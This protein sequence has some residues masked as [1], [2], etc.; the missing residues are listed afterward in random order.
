MKPTR[1]FVDGYNLTL[2]QGTGVATYARNL[3]RAL[4]GMGHDVGILYGRRAGASKDLLAR[5]IAFFDP[6]SKRV[7]KWLQ[8]LRGYRRLAGHPFGQK[9]WRVPVTGAVISQSLPVAD[10][11]WNVRDLF[12]LADTAF[13]ATGHRLPV[14]FP[15]PP[16]D[17]MHWTYPVPVSVKGA[18]N[19]YTLHDLVPLRLPFTTLDNKRR[20]LRLSREIAATAD[21]IV[22]VS[23]CSKRDIVELLGIAEDRVVNTYQSVEIPETYRTMSDA[24]V[25]GDIL[26]SFGL[27]SKG[28]YLFFGAIE[29]KKNVGRLI[30]AYLASGVSAP[31]VIVGKK[32]W[33]SEGELRLMF[34]DN[35]RYLVSDGPRTFTRNRIMLLDYAPFSLLMSLV[36]GAKAVLFPSLY[37][38]FGLPVL[39]AMHLGTPVMTSTAASLPELVG[40]AALTIDP[41]DVRGMVEAIRALDSDAALRQRLS[42]AGPVRA[43]MFSPERYRERLAAMYARLGVTQISP[44][45][46]SPTG[47]SS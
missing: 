39:E 9:A 29:P 6:A 2:E 36:R 41:Y 45:E 42:Q 26:G 43:E 15:E 17:I 25:S 31:L 12:P 1:I 22:T 32:A 35:I 34:D 46:D 47:A 14:K 18:R 20:Y 7:P 8:T 10:E 23:E 40:D 37:E 11:I 24:E 38:G 13:D 19:I 30:E 27:A 44:N 28:Y 16:P 5:E 21:L 3:S 4:R 33:K